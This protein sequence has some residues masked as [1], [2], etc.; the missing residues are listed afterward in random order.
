MDGNK[1]ARRHR[2]RGL[3]TLKS[4]L[5]LLLSLSAVYLTLLALD[6][7]RVEWA[8]IQAVLS[9]FRPEQEQAPSDAVLSGQSS[10]LSPTPV[11]LA[12]CDGTDRFASQYSQQQTD[13]LFDALGI[14]LSEALASAQAPVQ[15]GES[16][17]PRPH[18]HRPAAG[19]GPGREGAGAPVLS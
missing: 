5:I 14:L 19:G 1:R 10:T 3:E 8:P 6:Y 4:L 18:P 7:S 17:W 12:V 9:L 11:R 16:V 13:Q 15:V 2:R